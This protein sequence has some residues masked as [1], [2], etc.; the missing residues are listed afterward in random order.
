MKTPDFEKNHERYQASIARGRHPNSFKKNS[1]LWYRVRESDNRLNQI[2]SGSTS[3]ESYLKSSV[4]N[5]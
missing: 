2:K 3:I 1:E 4:K 5:Q